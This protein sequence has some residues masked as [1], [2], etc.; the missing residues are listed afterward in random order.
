MVRA[1]L[2]NR[3][4]QTRRVV[5][6]APDWGH[7]MPCPSETPEGWQGP[8]DYSLWAHEGDKSDGDVRRCPYGG[9][10]DRLWV[11]ETC[12]GDELESGQDGVSYLA[13]DAFVPIANTR[14]AALN[15]LTLHAYRGHHGARIGPKVPGIH[16]PRWASRITL[17]ITDVRVERLQEISFQDALAEGI[18]SDIIPAD[19]V[20]PN[21]ICYVTEPD[22]NHAYVKPGDA[23]RVLWENINGPGSWDANPWV[24]VVEFKR[25]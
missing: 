6:K 24:W 2:E 4:T 17:E 19:D 15:W 11:R 12:R 8:L 23:Y 3:K 10:G 21:R 22:D 7:P 9:P 16:M 18:R 20:G 14:A 25:A 1:L 13:D 5:W